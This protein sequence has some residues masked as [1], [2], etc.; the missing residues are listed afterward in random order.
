MAD[1]KHHTTPIDFSSHIANCYTRLSPSARNVADFLQQHPLATVTMSLVEIADKAKTSKASVSRFFRQLG[2]DSHLEARKAM[3]KQREAGLPIAGVVEE[4]AVEQERDNLNA[5]L[6]QLPDEQ[7]KRIAQLILNAKRVIVYGA[8]TSYPVAMT[9]CQQL[10]QVRSHVILLPHAG[11]SVSEDL[12]DITHDDIVLVSGFRRR[13]K[14][15]KSLLTSLSHCHTVLFTD[16]SGQVFRPLVN[17]LILC[18]LGQIQAFD[19]YTAPMAVVSLLCNEVYQLSS[20]AGQTRSHAISF[21]YNELD[22][23]S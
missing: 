15:F 21:L 2:F 13:P 7:I 23:L 4:N 17:D 16:S 6:K 9:L 20:E 3:L 22:E 5:T 19:S 8:R 10:K 1:K 11:Q 12:I 18:Q 14:I